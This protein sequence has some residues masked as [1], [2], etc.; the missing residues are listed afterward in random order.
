[1]S[2]DAYLRHA[3]TAENWSRQTVNPRERDAYL[4]IAALW[5]ALATRQAETAATSAGR[6][7]TA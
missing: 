3:A 7:A 4:E 5:R 1:M 6:Q 2:S